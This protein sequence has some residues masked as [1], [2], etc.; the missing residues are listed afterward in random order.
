MLDLVCFGELLIRM[1]AID[2]Y[3]I[4]DLKKFQPFLGGAEANVATGVAKLGNKVQMAGVLPNNSFGDAAIAE[5]RK[6]NVN[7]DK[8]ARAEGRMGLYFLSPGAIHRPSEILYDRKNSAFADY[9]FTKINWDEVLKGAK[10]F[11]ISGV[12]AALNQK[13]YEITL[14]LMKRARALGVKVSYD[15]NF[16][17]KL[18]A[19]W[20]SGYEDKIVKLMKN[21]DLIFAGH[22]D[23][24]MIFN[25]KYQSKDAEEVQ[26]MAANAAFDVF[27]NLTYLANTTRKQISAG[28]NQLSGNLFMRK[29]NYHTETFEI[30]GIVDRIGGGD[31]FCAGLLHGMI[32]HYEP[33]KSLDWAIAS[34]CLKHAQNGDLC[35]NTTKMIE[36]F[37]T[38]NFDVQR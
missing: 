35:L 28:Y 36:D 13:C 12:T 19:E 14:H 29:K 15:A 24:E 4:S 37:L 18:W 30:D 1:T 11:H 38:G 32:N 8:I 22:R 25:T 27:E 6:H 31:A 34:A 7:T 33:Q 9:D 20:S 3:V 16:R 21:A 23:F 17:P 5:L 2:G 10:W 26:S